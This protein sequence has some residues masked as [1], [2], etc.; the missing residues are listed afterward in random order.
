MSYDATAYQRIS[1]GASVGRVGWERVL[2]RSEYA[3]RIRWHR[4]IGAHID[5][6]GAR[7]VHPGASQAE[8]SKN[9]AD[10]VSDMTLLPY[11]PGQETLWIGSGMARAEVNEDELVHP[12]AEGAEAYYTYAAG[13]AAAFRLPDGREV[14]L[15]ELKV[16]PRQVRWNVVVGSLWFDVERGQLV[17]A[18]YR[19][20]EPLD[21]L[22][23]AEIDD[24]DIPAGVRAVISPLR[25]Q[26]TAMA[27][28]Y[29]LHQG[30]FWLPRLQS[31][32]GE[33]QA[34][35]MR[36]PF[37][38]Q[39]N[40][41]YASVNARGLD[42][43]API[44][45]PP[46]MRERAYADSLPEDQRE[47]WLDSARAVR[48]AARRARA[49]S[50]KKGLV[51]SVGACDTG[52]VYSA[53]RTRMN[54]RTAVLV[55]VPCD[56]EALA[57]SPELPKSIFA[58]TEELFDVAA[59]EALLE[60]A[61]SLGAQPE[62]SPRPPVVSYGLQF[63]RFNR[64]EGLSLGAGVTQQLGAGFVADA[65]LRFGLADREPN[66]EL[67]LARTNLSRTLRIGA[68]NRLLSASDWGN[69]LS[70]GS[71]MSALLWG[72]DEGFYYRA[73]GIDVTA[74]REQGALFTWRVFTEQQRAAAAE[75]SF[76]LAKLVRDA[77]FEPN[78][79]AARGHWTG[80]GVRAVHSTGLD[81]RSL[82]A[83]SDFRVEGAAGSSDSRGTSTFA[84][85][86]LDLTVSR[87]L[88]HSTGTGPLAALTVSGGSSVGDVPVQRLWFLGGSATVRG[89]AAGTGVGDAYWFSR[90]ELGQELG[91][92]RA[93][94]FG[95]AGWAG[96]RDAF[97]KDRAMSGA[98]VGYSLLDG[99]LRVDLA[100]GVHPSRAWRLHLYL[101]ARF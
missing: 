38:M 70:F 73:S 53:V 30:R 39:Q 24:G 2:F 67:G 19:L 76:S 63:L 18:A 55:R 99:L 26:V 68:Y 51:K 28:E 69:P 54:G 13:D 14:R 17:R 43:L 66:A 44:P 57:S 56:H 46:Y 6:L 94:L 5:V 78:I 61:L 35:F 90:L 11:Y 60:Q 27:V 47:A 71:S 40:F 8:A 52:T 21:I 74:T 62:F 33:A 45:T 48:T 1:A 32:E 65:T 12:L 16:R 15:R 80:A 29:G 79:T 96:S 34:S 83:L 92:G 31:V 4:D 100:K 84:R 91:P 87:A 58:D 81:P 9:M 50:V 72:R 77:A 88:G 85:A 95:D 10:D 86:A 101:E 97:S 20:A 22:A 42:S 3:S 41:R 64:I 59:Q 82:R 93:A 37:R 25:G 89:Q 7:R 36:V 23:N 75:N 98:G 49:D